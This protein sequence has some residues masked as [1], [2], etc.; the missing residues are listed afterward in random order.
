M[1]VCVCVCVG[2]LEMAG[3]CDDSKADECAFEAS[4]LNRMGVADSLGQPLQGLGEA[5]AAE[6]REARAQDWTA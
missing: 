3:Q 2:N 4:A 6:G 5:H 1:C